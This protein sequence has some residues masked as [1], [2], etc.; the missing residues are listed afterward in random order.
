MIDPVARR[1]PADKLRPMNRRIAF[2]LLALSG[3]LT[4]CAAL[5]PGEH[6]PRDRFERSNRAVYRFNDALD[7]HI[8]KPIARGYVKVTPRPVRTG[9]SNFFE[10]LGYTTV[11]VNDLL[12]GK[13]KSFGGDTARLV[14]NTTLGIGGLFDPATRM[15]L[16][17]GDEDFGQTLGKWGVPPGPY[18]VLPV[19]GPSNVRDTVGFV[20][21]QFTDPKFY[22]KNFYVSL[23]VTGMDLV[24]KRAELLSTDDVLGRAY[25]PYVF[26]RNAYLQRREYQVKDGTQADDVEIFEDDAS[27]PADKADAPAREATGGPSPAR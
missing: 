8:G 23:G 27:S 2:I 4:G 9:I 16:P 25:D 7:R 24:D 5:P 11:I 22:I 17:T 10:N 21:D 18:I 6:D 3:L 14:V 15:G 26:I 19:F 13:L 12:Q 20:G 1:P